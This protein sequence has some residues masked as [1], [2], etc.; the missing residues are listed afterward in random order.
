MAAD[1]RKTFDL[2]GIIV[3]LKNAAWYWSEPRRLDRMTF[4]ASSDAVQTHLRDT[5]PRVMAKADES[6][7][8][9]EI[10]DD[11]ANLLGEIL[12]KKMKEHVYVTFEEGDMFAGQYEDV[13]N[14]DEGRAWVAERGE[15][16]EE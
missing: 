9:H 16:I 2:D 8:S 3:D 13:A 6:G 1:I 12:A 4:I 5:F 15:K 14:K 10:E 7:F 11:Y